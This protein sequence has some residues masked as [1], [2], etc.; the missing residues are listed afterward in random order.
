[1]K[2]TAWLESIGAPG[3]QLAMHV[4]INGQVFW[5]SGTAGL[6]CGQH[7]MLAGISDIAQEAAIAAPFTGGVNGPATSPTIARIG[8]SLQSQTPTFMGFMM[9]HRVGDGKPAQGGVFFLR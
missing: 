8:S 7:G 2:K 1:M 4:A 5:Q 3:K 6:S 9:S